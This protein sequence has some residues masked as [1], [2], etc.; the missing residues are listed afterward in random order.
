[1]KSQLAQARRFSA[2]T[3]VPSGMTRPQAELNHDNWPA[4]FMEFCFDHWAGNELLK[5]CF[6]HWARCGRDRIRH[7]SGCEPPDW[8]QIATMTLPAVQ[9]AAARDVLAKLNAM[10]PGHSKPLFC[11]TRGGFLWRLNHWVNLTEPLGPHNTGMGVPNSKRCS[12]GD[13]KMDAALLW[14]INEIE[15]LSGLS[16]HPKKRERMSTVDWQTFARSFIASWKE[17][18]ERTFFWDHA[19]LGV[20]LS[21]PI[22]M[23][24]N[25]NYQVL[26]KA[27][28]GKWYYLQ[29]SGLFGY[30]MP[31]EFTLARRQMRGVRG[32]SLNE[33][34]LSGPTQ[35][36]KGGQACN[37]CGITRN[38][39]ETGPA[40]PAL[41]LRLCKGC[42]D[43][44]Y[45]SSSC[46]QEQWDH[47]KGYCRFRQRY[48]AAWRDD[49]VSAGEVDVAAERLG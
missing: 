29:L 21:L 15:H 8:S 3:Q 9:Q 39:I 41:K 18:M 12:T 37:Q 49:Y 23:P 33:M 14:F 20:F 34:T 5:S 26:S 1:M 13:P 46:Q 6:D 28:N 35:K 47:H 10:P 2:L 22:T 16:R 32:G 7:P 48:S 25:K 43:I 44:Y 11:S 31:V 24:E 4:D 36:A 40:T 45:C 30:P 38:Q 17:N 27:L 19:D 42:S